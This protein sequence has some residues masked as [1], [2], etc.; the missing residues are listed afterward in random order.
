M[1]FVVITTLAKEVRREDSRN[2]QTLD[3]EELPLALGVSETSLVMSGVLIVS[4]AMEEVKHNMFK[5]MHLI[6]CSH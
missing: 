4:H 6:A 1:D 3:V 2:C 5:F